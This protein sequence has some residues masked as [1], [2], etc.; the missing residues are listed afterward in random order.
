MR[1]SGGKLDFS[2]VD[3][4]IGFSAIQPSEQSIF[5]DTF[6]KFEALTWNQ[7]HMDQGLDYKE[8]HENISVTYHSIK[9][10]K[11][12]YTFTGGNE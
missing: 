2:R 9:T 1:F 12:R 6:R 10:Y 5:I 4:K 7:I 11:F 8:Y 3:E